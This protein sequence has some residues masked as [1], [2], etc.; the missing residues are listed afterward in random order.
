MHAR[1]L[2]LFLW[3]AGLQLVQ[4]PTARG[5]ADADAGQHVVAEDVEEEGVDLVTA[6][7]LL[8]PTLH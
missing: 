8:P 1:I 3:A 6:R 7:T 4:S 2:D 5:E